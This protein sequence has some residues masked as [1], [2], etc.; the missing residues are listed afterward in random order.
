M[1]TILASICAFAFSFPAAAQYR[2]MIPV[3]CG[4]A[5]EVE[6]TLKEKYGETP[7]W[8]GAVSESSSAFLTQSAGGS[9]TI[10]VRGANGSACIL[11]SGQAGQTVDP[12]PPKPEGSKS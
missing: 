10:Y 11:G 6:T 1:R 2:T 7:I 12:A 5:N 9:W 4:S 8:L 3:M